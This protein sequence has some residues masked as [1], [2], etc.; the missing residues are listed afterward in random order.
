MTLRDHFQ[1]D[2]MRCEDYPGEPIKCEKKNK[3]KKRLKTP[4]PGSFSG[5]NPLT[6]RYKI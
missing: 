5:T 3:N 1:W 2:E 4:N 6:D